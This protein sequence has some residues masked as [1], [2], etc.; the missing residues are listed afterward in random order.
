MS[1]ESSARFEQSPSEKFQVGD[2]AEGES[3]DTLFQALDGKGIPKLYV[4]EQVD[5]DESGRQIIFGRERTGK[6]ALGELEE[7]SP[8]NLKKVTLH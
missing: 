5:E 8:L 2:I 4:I 6:N 3:L 7:L 1:F